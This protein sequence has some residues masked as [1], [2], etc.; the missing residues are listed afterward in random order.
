[1]NEMTLP[2]R[3]MIRNSNPGGLS[4]STL[5]LGHGGSSQYCIITSERGRNIL[6][7]LNLK[8]RVGFE[9]AISDFP[10]RQPASTPAHAIE[11]LDSISRT[12]ST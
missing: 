12:N 2:F 3:H 11:R 9:P 8:V 7:R 6:F 5:T 4:P 10:S 1:M